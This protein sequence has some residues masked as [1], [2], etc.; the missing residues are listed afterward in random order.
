MCSALQNRW[1][2][3]SSTPKQLVVAAGTTQGPFTSEAAAVNAKQSISSLQYPQMTAVRV[4]LPLEDDAVSSPKIQAAMQQGH[5]GRHEAPHSPT[6]EA[7]EA[8]CTWQNHSARF[9]HHF[10]RA[11]TDST[12]QQICCILT[13]PSMIMTAILRCQDTAWQL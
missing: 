9:Q 11:F 5:L 4:A 8:C 1:Q 12:Q 2:M 6:A 13:K 10:A 7:C 3:S